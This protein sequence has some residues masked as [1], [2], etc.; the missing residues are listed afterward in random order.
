MQKI[1]NNISFNIENIKKTEPW[2]LKIHWLVYGNIYVWVCCSLDVFARFRILVLKVP[3]LLLCSQ[4]TRTTTPFCLKSYLPNINKVLLTLS[5]K[6]FL[7]PWPSLKLWPFLLIFF[8]LD[9][10]FK[11]SGQNIRLKVIFQ[12]VK[13]DGRYFKFCTFLFQGLTL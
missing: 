12:R 5:F 4:M 3:I 13:K 2:Q 9:Q 1:Q 8:I 7:Q 11:I 10:S 6:K